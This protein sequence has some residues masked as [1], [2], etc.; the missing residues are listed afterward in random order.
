MSQMVPDFQVRELDFYSSEDLMILLLSVADSYE[1]ARANENKHLMHVLDVWGYRI[2]DA[3]KGALGRETELP[4]R[5]GGTYAQLP[6]T[7]IN[8]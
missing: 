1:R 7:K 2:R 6:K 4:Y 3:H 5:K 8:P